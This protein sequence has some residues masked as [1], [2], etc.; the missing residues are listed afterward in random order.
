MQCLQERELKFGGSGT[1]HVEIG[2]RGLITRN[3]RSM[4]AISLFAL[5]TLGLVFAK[6]AAT[7]QGIDRITQI[8]AKTPNQSDLLIKRGLLYRLDGKL[9]ESLRD[10]DRA[11]ELDQE[12]REIALQRA[13]TL[14]A[15]RRDKEAAAEWGRLLEAG[16]ATG[17]AYAER[18]RIRGRTGRPELAIADFTAAISIHPAL[19]LYLARGQLEES[20]G[21]LNEAAA[22]YRDG[23]SRLGGAILLKTALIRV[24]IARKR[25]EV[26]LKLIDEELSRTSVKTAWY[27]RRADVFAALGELKKAQF[28][29]EL[30]LAEANRVLGKR[31]TVIHL[32]SRA[33]VYIAMDRLEDAKRDLQLAFRKAPRFS[34]ANA[35]WK[36]LEGENPRTVRRR[37]SD[38]GS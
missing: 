31:P 38:E 22:G 37:Q 16:R 21:K 2:F 27:L 33:K 34:E 36:E 18:G 13:L 10:L 1:Q 32:L 25:Y 6:T 11:R 12:N 7:D 24:E 26:A 29:L 4:L 19:E 15:L 3:H 35:L 9:V 30:A 28:E 20:L 8:L 5:A 14:S 23:L 17:L